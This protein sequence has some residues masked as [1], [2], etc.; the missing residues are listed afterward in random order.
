LQNATTERIAPLSYFLWQ[1]FSSNEVIKIGEVMSFEPKYTLTVDMAKNLMEIQ[2]TAALISQ[3][4][5]PVYIL[6]EL[7]D[8]SLIE[9]VIY[10]TKIEGNLLAE[11]HKR[12]AINY[13]GDRKEE[14]EVYNLGKALDFIVYLPPEA[15]DVPFL[16]E[17]LVAW[18]NNPE[19]VDLPAP[20]KAG[21]FLYQFLTIHPYMDKAMEETVEPWLHI[22][23][24]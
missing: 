1:P 4:P 17:E 19:N 3:L 22:F 12:E 24:A 6:K 8:E 15:K 10:F 11:K 16:M 13:A 14:Q 21:I 2:K 18:I 5:L 9:T 20:L 7:K 23:C